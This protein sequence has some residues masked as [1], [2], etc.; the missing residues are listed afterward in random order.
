M[1]TLVSL[2]RREEDEEA[3]QKGAEKAEEAARQ[4]SINESKKLIQ[5]LETNTKFK[6][7]YTERKTS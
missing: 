1:E 7:T 4:A 3:R 6:V 5:N 2:H